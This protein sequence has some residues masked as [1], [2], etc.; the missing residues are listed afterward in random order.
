MFHKHTVF[1]M[2]RRFIVWMEQV[3]HCHFQVS[4]LSHYRGPTLVVLVLEL[5]VCGTGQHMVPAVLCTESAGL[6]EPVELMQGVVL[7]CQVEQM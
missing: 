3:V 1:V 6:T 4:N 5:A 2:F 7:S